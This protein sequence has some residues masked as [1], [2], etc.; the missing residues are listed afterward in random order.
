MRLHP[1]FV[2]YLAGQI[3]ADLVH[4]KKVK[5]ADD[6]FLAGLIRNCIVSDLE[7]EEALNEEAHE[8]LKE[9]YETIR[10]SGVNYDEMFRKIKAQ[11]AKEKGIKL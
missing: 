11:L 9:H 4:A 5:L 1:D 7:E 2:E 6:R 8:V 3:A 10:S